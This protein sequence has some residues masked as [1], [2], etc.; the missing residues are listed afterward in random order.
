MN[1]VK[2][3]A[4]VKS[5]LSIT[6]SSSVSKALAVSASLAAISIASAAHATPELLFGFSP[7]DI[8]LA[9]SGVADI[10]SSDPSETS[11]DSHRRAPL[12]STASANPAF[13]WMPGVR[14]AAGYSHGMTSLK[15][16]GADSGVADIAGT[17]LA[18]QW[19]GK[20]GSFGMIGGGMNMHL[21]NRSLAKIAFAPGTEPTFVRFDPVSQRTTF[22]AAIALRLG[23]LSIGAGASVLV[24]AN[25]ELD[26]MLGQDLSGAFAE[27]T[28][29]IMVPYDISPILGL[30]V[31]LGSTGLDLSLGARYRGAQAVNL[32][33]ASIA[34][35]DVQ[36][37][38]LNGTTTVAINGASGYV[39]TTI[40][41]AARCSPF[42]GLSL[43][44]SLQYA[45]WS[46][47]PASAAKMSMVVDL[48]LVP[49]QMES[50]F[51]RPGFRDTLSPR[52]GLELMPGWARSDLVFRAGYAF[53]PSPVSD[54]HGFYTPVDASTHTLGAGAG[55]NIGTLWGVDTR[56]DGAVQWLLLSDRAF[57]KGRDSLPFAHYEATGYI[58]VGSI[59]VQGTWQ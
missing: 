46:Q 40:D 4:A 41:V 35:V 45:R 31:D 33:F 51:V 48:G 5:Y 23:W 20:L 13:L 55:Y 26:L 8:A 1:R 58:V 43:M 6:P 47:A 38:P 53:T 7:R 39:P 11:S 15:L 24:S 56:I 37:N 52:V 57:D 16:N 32:E 50:E 54:S 12:A 19:G 36:G 22:D 18:V 59:A 27:G 34:Q 30:A 44:T 29:D 3:K 9:Q 10:P 14:V 42:S 17:Q 2:L 21:P 28:A 49:G 25:G